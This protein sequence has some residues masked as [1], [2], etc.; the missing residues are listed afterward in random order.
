MKRTSEM[1]QI[2]RSTRTP[3]ADRFWPKVAKG[4]PN[5]CW[6][7]QASKQPKGYGMIGLP[8]KYGGFASAHR[9]AW[10]LECGPIP[11]GLFVCH[12]CDNPPCVNPKHLFLGTN[13]DN[14]DD[15]RK[16]RRRVV[17]SDEIMVAAIADVLAGKSIRA[18][19]LIHG[20]KESYLGEIMRAEN[21]KLIAP[22]G[23]VSPAH[24]DKEI[25]QAALA[26]IRPNRSLSSVAREFGISSSYFCKVVRE[27]K[28]KEIAKAQP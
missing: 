20:I 14:M 3:L 6:I 19:A 9:V 2:R 21:R 5:A 18:S 12:R 26:A 23:W 7:W 16:K 4:D 15:M 1:P 11:N 17:I 13:Q 27:T 24:I 8:G 25:L 10:E 22:K 28:R